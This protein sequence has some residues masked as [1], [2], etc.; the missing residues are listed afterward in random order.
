M[1]TLICI[2]ILAFGFTALRAQQQFNQ[3]TTKPLASQGQL[4]WVKVNGGTSTSINDISFPSRDT[5]YA[6][7]S[8]VVLRSIDGGDTWQQI[9][10]PTGGTGSFSDTKNGY[11]VGDTRIPFHTVDGGMTWTPCADDSIPAPTL[12]LAL[13]RDTVFVLGARVSRSVDGGKTWELTN[14]YSG[15]QAI[16]FYDAKH[17]IMVGFSGSSGFNAAGCYTTSNGGSTWIPQSTGLPGGFRGVRY[18]S[19]DTIVGVGG[20]EYTSGVN[21]GI[22]RSTNGGRTWDS[23]VTP[24]IKAAAS[25]IDHKGNRSLLVVGSTILS[26]TDG[27]TT[28]LTENSG[29]TNGLNSVAMLDGST[30]LVGGVQGTI[31]KTTNGGTDWVQVSPPSSQSLS[32]LSFQDPETPN[33]EI[34][35][36]LPQLQ[37]VKAIVYNLMGK[38]IATLANGELQQPGRQ[39]LI[40]NS[41]ALPSG[42]YIITITTNRYHAIGKF[43]ITH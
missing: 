17:G 35:Y 8:S 34:V 25:G 10:A 43:E 36:D 9:P 24:L 30:A 6:I 18:L 33:V 1:K 20:F 38:Q 39:R 11:V 22:A 13:T 29:V 37:N 32:V 42:T 19:K 14:I 15:E 28:W 4:G 27:G 3:D 21:A 7:G 5:A 31:L 40:F 41:T 2:L 23:V 16:D 12:L 26:S